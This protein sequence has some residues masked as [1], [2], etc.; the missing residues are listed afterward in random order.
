MKNN[1]DLNT[2][3]QLRMILFIGMNNNLITYPIAPMTPNPIAHDVAILIN[4][5]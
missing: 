4:S 5:K 1:Y 2:I 3:I